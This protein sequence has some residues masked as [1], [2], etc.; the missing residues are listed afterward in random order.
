MEQ[1]FRR[2]LLHRPVTA[3]RS[4]KHL[5]F[6]PHCHAAASQRAQT[7]HRANQSRPRLGAGGRRPPLSGP[8][9]NWLAPSRNRL[10]V[11]RH[12]SL[13]LG[14]WRELGGRRRHRRGVVVDGRTGRT[15]PW[16]TLSDPSPHLLASRKAASTMHLLRY[17][18][19]AG[20]YPT[21]TR[22]LRGQKASPQGEVA[23]SAS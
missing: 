13:I 14:R 23:A 19:H 2:L 5:L 3:D 1:R 9:Q 11:T 6:C 22:S 7:R 16:L 4:S 17:V 10:P 20:D 21:D 18:E 15:L 12:P 8:R